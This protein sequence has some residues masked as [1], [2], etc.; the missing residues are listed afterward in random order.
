MYRGLAI[1]AAAVCLVFPAAAVPAAPSALRADVERYFA[2][3]ER[4]HPDPYHA[5][6]RDKMRA[7]ADGIVAR[8]ENLGDDQVMVELMRLVALLGERDGHAGLFPFDSHRRTMHA[9]PFWTYLFPDGVFV[10][11]TA[12]GARVGERLVAV[13]GRPVDDVLAAI[14]PLQTR[15]NDWSRK[16]L[17]PM[18]LASAEVLHGLGVTP[19]AERATFTFESR[20][21]VRRDVTVQARPFSA[22]RSALRPRFRAYVFGL[23]QQA[24]PLFLSHLKSNRWLTT[25]DHG[26]VVYVSYNLVLGGTFDFS[27][28]LLRAARKPKVR[29]VVI[30]L[31]NN[32]GGEIKTYPPLLSVL[33]SRAINRPARLVLLIGRTT[34]SAAVH[35]T[36][37]VQMLTRARLVGEPTGGAPNHWSDTD[38]VELENTGLIVRVPTVYFEKRPGEN[39]TAIEPD[40]RVDLTAAVYFAKRDPVLQAALR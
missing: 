4:I 20:A 5:T 23:P 40:E 16:N 28:R 37:D 39:L 22:V 11:A 31:R 38:P 13:E 7:T 2:E 32:P 35:F 6:P 8:A 15:D 3:L 21:G 24:K 19:T 26:R 29:R 25:L 30:D 27:D 9:Y 14:E 17:A 18:F 12:G 34:F 33:T 1:A 10:V 36:A